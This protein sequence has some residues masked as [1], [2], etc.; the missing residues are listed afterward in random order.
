MC[1]GGHNVNYTNYGQQVSAAQAQ[2]RAR[3]HGSDWNSQSA[4]QQQL[5]AEKRAKTAQHVSPTGLA[6]YLAPPPH[7]PWEGKSEVLV[8]G[9]I[10]AW[11]VWRIQGRPLTLYSMAHDFVWKPK[12]VIGGDVLGGYGVHAYKDVYG[13]VNDGYVAPGK[14]YVVGSVALW[15]EVIEH[16]G[17]Y[18]AQYAKILSLDHW[19]GV[20]KA[21]Q[22]VIRKAYL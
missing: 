15:G 14:D 10:V 12:T 1:G 16:E 5:A 4:Y 21:E 9:E 7:R 8:P 11:R 3:G 2:S 22:A 20:T 18:R 19:S 17:G 13:P 6:G